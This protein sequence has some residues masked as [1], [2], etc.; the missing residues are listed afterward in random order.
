MSMSTHAGL[1]RGVA[2][3]LGLLWAGWWMSVGTLAVLWGDE[4]SPGEWMYGLYGLAGL[5]G[6]LVAW[7]WPL[8]GGAFIVAWSLVLAVVKPVIY[9]YGIASS[10]LMILAP[11]L[12]GGLF[13]ALGWRA[14]YA[15]HAP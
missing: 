14:R 11:L 8:A 15:L 5:V 2:T 13:I 6:I 4:A 3:V 1:L 10:S 12:A 7:R 9:S